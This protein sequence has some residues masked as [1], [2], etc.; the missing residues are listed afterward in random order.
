MKQL[1]GAESVS[2]DRS[3]SSMPAASGSGRSGSDC[4]P[5]AT[6]PLINLMM[7]AGSKGRS[8]LLAGSAAIGP[9]LQLL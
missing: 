3:H 6:N 4:F 2:T 5:Y 8:A 7:L 9:A 1:P